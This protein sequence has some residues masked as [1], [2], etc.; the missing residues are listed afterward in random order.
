[1]D[2]KATANYIERMIGDALKEAQSVRDG[3]SVELAKPMAR[4]VGITSTHGLEHLISVETVAHAFVEIQDVAGGTLEEVGHEKFLEAVRT[5][6]GHIQ[7]YLRT[8]RVANSGIY[9]VQLLAMH[10]AATKVLAMTDI[11]NLIDDHE[12]AK[13]ANTLADLREMV[14]GLRGD[15]GGSKGA[16]MA[17]LVDALDKAG[18]FNSIDEK[19]GD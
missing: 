5:V 9:A 4:G 3:L 18:V 7:R 10:N 19:V 15:K 16:E 17:A 1:M 13:V 8:S 12:D 14:D 2:A 11:I 6:R